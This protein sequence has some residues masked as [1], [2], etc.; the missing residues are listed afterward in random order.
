MCGI[1]L[2]TS[3]N[4]SKYPINNALNGI[5]HRGPDS[6]GT[7][8]SD[9]K[10]CHMGHVRLSIL[11][12]SI[13]GYQP[14]EDSSGRYIISFNGEIYN[15]LELK[16]DLISKYKSIKFKTSTD[17][18]V[19]LEGFAREG[20]NFF[21][22]L[23]GMF[24]F[25]IFDKKE[26]ILYVLRDP[27]GVKPL[28]Y[29]N[30]NES[31]FF[32]SELKGL[33]NIPN[34]K[35]TLNL[36]SLA[37][38]LS[39]MYV[40]EPNT[41][42]KEYYKMEPGFLNMFHKGKKISKEYLYQSLYNKIEFNSQTEVLET[43]N[44][45]FSKSIKRQLISD[46]PVSIMLSGGI[47][48]SAIAHEVNSQSGNIKDA[49]TI[50]LSSKDNKYDQQ[51]NDFYYAKLIA[52]KYNLKLNPI[53]AEKSFLSYI[54]DLSNFLEDGIS[55]PA[56]IN[57]YLI[58]KE[59]RKNGIK[60]LLTGQG[61]DEYLYGYRRYFAES[62][63]Q[64]IPYSIKK[65]I[66]FTEKFIPN[67]FPGFLNSSIRRLK[68]ISILAGEEN[69]SDRLLRMYLTNSS[70][71][72]S[73][74]FLNNNEIDVGGSFK[75][76]LFKIKDENP[77]QKMMKIDQNYDLLS[78]NLAYTDRMSMAS[79]VEAR[80]PFLDFD[81][82]RI[83][84]SISPSLKLKKG[85]TKYLLKQSMKGHLP[86]EVVNREKAGFFLPIR[87]WLRNESELTKELFDKDK[88][89]KQGIFNPEK[90]EI[91]CQEQFNNKKDNANLMFSF[92]CIQEWLNNNGI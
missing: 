46:V 47:D 26:N 4:A 40:P 69:N 13:A 87:S 89:K 84:N 14:M 88:L 23:N 65:S 86:K 5:I 3:K 37:D 29:T 67:N 73:N 92:L 51:S 7:F 39:Y 41:L 72:I 10:E 28:F 50:T 59:A 57:T 48:S 52:N 42:Y 78:L 21:S 55:D 49:Y 82:V 81:L 2:I 11:D 6:K 61:A 77:L 33:T 64:K 34:L 85:T 63:F 35:K 80:V 79:G 27:L 18:E 38:Q 74:L 44:A 60:V 71:K 54:K 56:A 30:Q 8:L 1:L 32:S 25:G 66:A 62:F 70:E 15:Y 75:K 20:K 43:F 31:W 91:L 36:Q 83:M 17:T 68:T 9:N 53:I 12:T 58:S 45:T 22:K 76:L 16:S 24:A 19:I 90:V